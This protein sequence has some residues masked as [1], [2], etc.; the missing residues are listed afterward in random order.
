[1][2]IEIH[3]SVLNKPDT[4]EIRLFPD[5]VK[6]SC[7]VALS[8]YARVEDASIEA[9]VDME[10][11]DIMKTEKLKVEL[12]NLPDYINSFKYNPTQV[13]YIIEKK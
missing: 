5:A 13:E 2:L 10:N 7:I 8:N 6:L 1:M 9:Y 3:I 11:I 4:A 12:N